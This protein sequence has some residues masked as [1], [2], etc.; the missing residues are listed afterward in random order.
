MACTITINITGTADD[1]VA[2]A[3]AK[4]L[5]NEGIFDGDSNSGEFNVPLPLGQQIAGNYTINRPVV[6]INITQKP[7]FISCKVIENYI[8][9]HL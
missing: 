1:L 2:N 9:T 4:V 3:K 5:A 8:N 7:F 6:T